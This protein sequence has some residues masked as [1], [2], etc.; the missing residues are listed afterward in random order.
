MKTL[1]ICLTLIFAITTISRAQTG[2][3]VLLQEI[4]CPNGYY[5]TAE[6]AQY[7]Y[8]VVENAGTQVINSIDVYYR[9]DDGEAVL[10]HVAPIILN[11]GENRNVLFPQIVLPEGE[12]TFTAWV[13]LGDEHTDD[14]PENNQMSAV[15]VVAGGDVAIQSISG[16]P[17]DLCG[18]DSHTPIVY[19]L[20]AGQIDLL[21]FELSLSINGQLH[22]TIE[23]TGVLSPGQSLP[24]SFSE[25]WLD[26]GQN[27]LAFHIDFPNESIDYDPS[28]NSLL[29][30]INITRGNQISVTIDTDQFGPQNHFE[31]T[32]QQGQIVA[33]EGPF[34]QNANLLFNYCLPAGFYTF[35]M[36]D[37]NGN[38]MC[39]GMQDGSYIVSNLSTS[40]TIASGCQFAYEIAHTFAVF[41]P[42]GPPV[43]DFSFT[44]LMGCS[45]YF[46]FE[47]VVFT[48]MPVISYSWNFGDDAGSGADNPVHVYGNSGTY[49][50]SL[51]VENMY[52]SAT[53]S[54]TDCISVDV[55]ESPAVTD[56]F[57][58]GPGSVVLQAGEPGEDILWF[59]N[60]SDVE[61]FHAGNSFTTP[62]LTETTQYFVE[63]QMA[64]SP[65]Q[66]FGMNQHSGQGGF[67][68]WNINR[69]L[70]FDA[71]SD[72]TMVS[73]KVYAQGSGNRTFTLY[74]S[75]DE[76][77]S[78]KIIFVPAGESRIQLDFYM[79]Q[80]NDYV[81][82]VSPQNNLQYTGDY[83]G[84][85]FPYPYTVNGLISYT[86]NNYSNSFYYFLYD[87]E[88]F[89][90][91]SDVCY[92]GRVPVTANIQQP[93]AQL[94]A[95]LWC[96]T[97][98]ECTISAAEGYYSYLWSPGGDNTPQLTVN[99]AG[100]YSVS[101]TDE[102]GC[103]ASDVVE[104]SFHDQGTL[105]IESHSSGSGTNNGWAEAIVS[106]GTPPFLYAWS[107][108]ETSSIITGLSAGMYSVTVT[109][110]AGC[111][112]VGETEIL[113]GSQRVFRNENV[114]FY[115]NPANEIICFESI[116]VIN[117]MQ[118][119]NVFGRVIA[120][121]SPV[122]NKV[123]YSLSSLSSGVYFVKVETNSGLT[124]LKFIKE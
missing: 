124:L 40:Q 35:T 28:N 58:C 65:H 96:C 95:N 55:I 100:E 89:S 26:N 121:L 32:N 63:L 118:I 8:V 73:A 116:D 34:S 49:S 37:A 20:N 23:W 38:G 107:N 43:I 94:P 117:T 11:Q 51:T 83:N 24:I 76:M 21:S 75:S 111:E 85:S 30:D 87:I 48:E 77:I 4:V 91:A 103:T 45:G 69:T 5:L 53:Y 71:L 92:S 64:G 88:V 39:Q 42:F 102:F 110:A 1:G 15:F 109:D 99:V 25:I 61:S 6:A 57:S 112:L 62:I 2:Y 90:G 86:G 41:N 74:N 66:Y 98:N 79:P 9:I 72:V 114:I 122:N 119:Y 101:V 67:F 106:G 68:G 113:V 120:I 52:G 50:V 46:V 81:I 47:S 12:H 18:F 31:I 104:V 70:F 78:Q 29:H 115:P 13:S 59:Y 27:N 97:G 60:Q 84:P 108:G 16:L 36:F 17:D 93:D 54:C 19:A 10:R 7:P 123:A 44:Q 105:S 56:N 33:A 3:D 22:Q 82:A 80:G 14:N